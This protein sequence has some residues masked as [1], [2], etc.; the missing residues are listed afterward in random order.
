MLF[1]EVEKLGTGFEGALGILEGLVKRDRYEIID[2]NIWWSPTA[3][4]NATIEPVDAS[5]RTSELG[6]DS[7]ARQSGERVSRLRGRNIREAPGSPQV[8]L[9]LITPDGLL[10]PLPP[11]KLFVVTFLVEAGLSAFLVDEDWTNELGDVEEIQRVYTFGL[12]DLFGHLLLVFSSALTWSDE[13]R[14]I[15]W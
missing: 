9:T 3:T 10:P 7:L 2:T 1:K 11:L 5:H 13:R 12:W 8:D 15:S 4:F 14:T 6:G